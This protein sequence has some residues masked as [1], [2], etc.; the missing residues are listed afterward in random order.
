M[1][2][3]TPYSVNLRTLENVH[4]QFACQAQRDGLRFDPYSQ[5]EEADIMPRLQFWV[6]AIVAFAILGM[7]TPVAAQW[8]KYPAPGIPRTPDGKPNLTAPA[9]RTADGKADLSGLWQRI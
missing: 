6:F 4:Q 5:I 8:M 1:E 9:P 2:I 3:G 7:T